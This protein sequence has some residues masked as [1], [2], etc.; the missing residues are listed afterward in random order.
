MKLPI[1]AM[2]SSLAALAACNQGPEVDAKNA[3]VEEVAAKV[4]EATGDGQ[5]IRAGEWKSTSAIEEMTVP[6]L[7]AEDNARMKQ[8]MAKS[9][10]HEFTTCLTEEDVKQPEGK[11]FTGNDQC[12]YDHFTMSRGKIDAAMRCQSGGGGAQVMKMS[13]TYAPDN[14]QMRMEMKGEG[15]PGA[16]GA[17][18]AMIMRMRVDSKR[19]GDCS[20]ADAKAAG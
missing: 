10:I 16:T 7:S 6:G 14:Y 19:I 4:R 13:G 8:V 17:A 15:M 3:S 12:R 9:G 5:F 18:G 11:F 1:I 2:L 20:A